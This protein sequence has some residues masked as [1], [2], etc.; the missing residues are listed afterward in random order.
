M[1]LVRTQKFKVIFFPGSEIVV[2]FMYI[3]L[4]L[5]QNQKCSELWVDISHF[6][7]TGATKKHI[8]KDYQK[9]PYLKLARWYLLGYI[10][11]KNYLNYTFFCISL[12]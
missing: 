10:Y 8:I 1:R 12:S 2:G 7:N 3:Y 4:A 9:I 11:K 6:H 5:L